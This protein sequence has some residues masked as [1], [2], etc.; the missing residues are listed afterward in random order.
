[1]RGGLSPLQRYALDVHGYLLLERALDGRSVRR[2]KAAVEAQRLPR[3]DLT[4][5]RQ[6]FGQGGRLFEWDGAF[7]DLVDHPW[8]VAV[9]A[10]V[11]GPHV[12]LDHAYGIIM[13]PGTAGLGLHGPAEPFDPAQY[14]V[15]RMGAVRSGLLA[16][17][18]SLVDGRPG[19]GGFGCIP[20]SHKAAD[21]LPV[22]AESMIVEVPQ[23]AGSLLVFTEALAHCTIPWRGEETR[24]A[25]LFKYSPGSSAWDPSPAA[26]PDVVAAMPARRRLYFQ[27]PSVGG[28]RPVI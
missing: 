2:L 3:P 1:M 28:H 22:G 24:L 7:G 15:S 23:P 26:P 19:Q 11:I 6:R 13:A 16:F 17:S 4:I 9:L 8:V 5:E 18:W 14:W 20:G 27:P 21:P 10:D 12:R 25:L